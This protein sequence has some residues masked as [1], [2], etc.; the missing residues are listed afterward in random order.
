MLSSGWFIGVCS[1]NA[2][3][4]EHCLFNLHTYPPMKM[5]ETQCSKT[6]AFKLQTPVNHP[7]ES[8]QHSEHGESLKLGRSYVLMA[9]PCPSFYAS[10]SPN[11]F[12]IFWYL[13]HFVWTLDQQKNFQHCLI[14]LSFVWSK[15]IYLKGHSATIFEPHLMYV[16]K[17]TTLFMQI[18]RSKQKCSSYAESGFS[19]ALRGVSNNSWN[20][21]C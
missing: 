6:L 7:E 3:V 1:L 4:S 14:Y 13:W 12:W 5:E 15:R 8:I 19:F 17:N 21:V 9:S 20:K 10:V 2:N 16:A 18:I 11:K